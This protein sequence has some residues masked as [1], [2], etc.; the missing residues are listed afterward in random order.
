MST[1]GFAG[2]YIETL[3]Y[4]AT[5]AFWKSLGFKNVFETD[6]GSGQ[7][8]HSS[9]GPYVFIAERAD[10]DHPLQTYPVL[11]VADSTRFAPDRKPEY[12]RPF[13]PQHWGVVE[14]LVVDP[15]GRLVSLQAPIPDGAE[16]PDMDAHHEH[17]Y[18]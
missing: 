1:E 6:H 13:Q 14:A 17:K 11:S 15:D 3:N 10:P 18:G 8:K 7:W 4:G 5:A 2:F 9:G 12:A 16:A